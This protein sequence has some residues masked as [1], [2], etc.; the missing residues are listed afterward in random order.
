MSG[1][2]REAPSRAAPATSDGTA[3]AEA[4]EPFRQAMAAIG[5]R[6]EA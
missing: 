5:D 3:A 6:D 4:A 2:S 1:R